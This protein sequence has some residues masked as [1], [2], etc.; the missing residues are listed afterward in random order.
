M[1]GK[2]KI[3]GNK[4]VRK[5]LEWLQQQSRR[6]NNVGVIV[7]YSS[8]YA[9]YVHE[10]R[11]IH[12]PGMILAGKYRKGKKHKGRYWDPQGRAQPKFLEQPFRELRSELV[13]TVYTMAKLARFSRG[14]GLDKGLYVAG[15]RL[16]RE[17]QELVPVEFG[18]L[19]GSAF[20][21]LIHDNRD[22]G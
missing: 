15:L 4:A 12:P 9:L 5:K 20:T 10:N 16:Q 11:E 1:I 13:D 8:S 22:K 3:D 6:H 19:K 18:F 21:R 17:S 7:G 2:I 14:N